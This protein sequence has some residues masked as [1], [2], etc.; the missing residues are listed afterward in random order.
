MEISQ[1]IASIDFFKQDKKPLLKILSRY[2]AD[3]SSNCIITIAPVYKEYYSKLD[4]LDFLNV[5]AKQNDQIKIDESFFSL[6]VEQVGDT[7]E[8]IAPNHRFEMRE[9]IMLQL[10]LNLKK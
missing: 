3:C 4:F 10:G 9:K 7:L 6:S 8:H 2:I 5:V 1:R